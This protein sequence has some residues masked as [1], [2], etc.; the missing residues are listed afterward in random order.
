[1]FTRHLVTR[2]SLLIGGLS[3]ALVG[4]DQP[5][6]GVAGRDDGPS[7]PQLTLPS[8]ADVG[9]YLR[10]GMIAAPIG[11]VLAGALGLGTLAVALESVGI[12]SGRGHQIYE[13]IN[14]INQL[15]SERFALPEF[16]ANPRP[17]IV[18][19]N[20]NINNF[21][22]VPVFRNDVTLQFGVLNEEGGNFGEC[23]IY[24]AVKSVDERPPQ[25][26]NEIW[27]SGDLPHAIVSPAPNGNYDGSL[28]IGALPSGAFVSYSWKVPRGQQPTDDYIASSAFVGPAFLSIDDANYSI[29]LAE[30]VEPGKNVEARFQLPDASL[31]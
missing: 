4:C 10:L 28:P 27:G 7:N 31:G 20:G 23:D 19:E 14:T 13:L 22:S 6:G 16:N 9:M 1:M 17:F 25:T 3:I 24:V 21:E 2:R 18:P 11:G 5:T 15:R 8:W 26:L 12:F 30:A 29:D